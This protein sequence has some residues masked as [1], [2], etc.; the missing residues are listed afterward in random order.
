MLVMTYFSD[1]WNERAL[2]GLF[3]QAWILP[4][5]IALLV[6]P[7]SASPWARYAILTVLLSYPS[8]VCTGL[9]VGILE[10]I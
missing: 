4:N 3:G 5:L 7:A 8:G 2:L 6:L 9:P 10:E 1:I